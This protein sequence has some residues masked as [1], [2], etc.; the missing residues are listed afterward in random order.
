MFSEVYLGNPKLKSSNVTVRY[1]KEQL[2]EFIRCAEDPIYFIRNYIKIVHVDRGLIPFD[3][4]DFQE[5]I[6]KTIHNNRF[7]ICKI[8]RQA[9]SLDTPI[10]TPNGWTTMGAVKKGDDIFGQNGK[11]T[12]VLGTSNI[13]ESNECYKIEFD[14]GETIIA[15]KEHLWE[16][17]TPDWKYGGPRILTTEKII[18]FFKS[19]QKNNS[20]IYIENTKPLELPEQKDLK[21]HPYI[22][23]VW[24]GDGSS[25]GGSYTNHIDD[26]EITQ[27]IEKFG[28][29]T[30]IGRKSKTSNA[31]TRTIYGLHTQLKKIGLLK[32]CAG[33]FKKI[34]PKEYLRSSIEQRLLLLQ[35]LMDT[36]GSCCP[37]GSC[38]FYQKNENLI[39]QVRELLS[40]LGIK[41]RLRPYFHK[42]GETYYTLS[43]STIKF[44]V[45]KL[46]RKLNRQKNLLN[47]PKNTRIYF[48]NITKIKNVPVKC[49]RVD[50]E[51]NLFLC[52]LTMIPTHNSGK[53]TTTLAYLLHYILFNDLVS[54]VVLANKADTAQ[55]LL[56][57]LQLAYENLPIW[58]QNGIVT[59]NKRNIELENGSKIKA[60]ATS[61]AAIRGGA[62]NIIFLD[63]FAHIDNTL[64]DFFFTSVYPTISSGQTTKV[65]V[66]STP[67]GM[68]HFYKMWI[69]A[70]QAAML[71]KKGKFEEAKKISRF[72]T[73]EIHYSQVPGRDDDWREQEIANLGSEE[74]FE[75]EYGCFTHLTTIELKDLQDESI[76]NL[77]IGELYEKLQ[78]LQESNI[79]INPN[80][81]K[82]LTP[83]GFEK[84]T[85]VQKVV[86]PF[87]IRLTFNDGSDVICSDNHP[88][89]SFNNSLVFAGQLKPQDYIKSKDSW[90]WVKSI[91]KIDG[92]IELYDIVDSGIDNLY[93]ANNVVSHNCEFI[94]SSRTLISTKKLRLLANLH[95]KPIYSQNGLD[96]YKDPM[97]EVIEDEDGFKTNKPHIY[98]LAADT[99]QGKGLD[100]SS[101]I[102]VDVTSFP[103]EVVAKYRSNTIS[104]L[105][106]PE[107]LFAVGKKYNNAYILIEIADVGYSVSQMLHYDLEY[108]NILTCTTKGRAGQL[109]STGHTKTT[110]F[111]VKMTTPVKKTGCANLKTLI[112]NNKLMLYD[113]DAIAELTTFVNVGN[114]YKAEEGSHDDIVMSM[115]VFSWVASQKYFRELID[116]D[117]RLSLKKDMEDELDYNMLPAPIIGDGNPEQVEITETDVWRPVAGYTG[118]YPI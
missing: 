84:F 111:G 58:L 38:E 73:I 64:A 63:E 46:S 23:G 108:E 56:S 117:I 37:N 53:S 87:C 29:K 32:K 76:I 7:S 115:V 40:S 68:N 100:Y 21:I 109:L 81:Y 83:N 48:K 27:Y 78:A 75:Q 98:V 5:D 15:D 3:M 12:K 41:S 65:I 90:L 13:M 17:N 35:G 91:E 61:S 43:F 79:V 2:E 22:L 33:P 36:D 11:P 10:P 86:K 8:P 57:R 52:G 92:E 96:V 34:I 47:H 18:P 95:K 1:T 105:V 85:G 62:Y 94:G 102:V 82:I 66:V 59:W 74:K 42:N 70:E 39:H 113:F 25:Y 118:F 116:S 101:L 67:L 44:E 31:E 77:S 106:F 89:I 51:S 103:Y 69:E 110:Q 55:E 80:R 19:K 20:G 93:Y 54:V 49:I 16:V 45:F 24:L 72:V 6:V 112:E 4:W 107:V 14:N 88:L 60:S 99:A 50:N 28:Y 26:I 30:S 104:H 97:I 114:S 71:R 9:L